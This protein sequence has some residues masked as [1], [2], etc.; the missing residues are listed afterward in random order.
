MRG[1]LVYLDNLKVVLTVV[2]IF[3]HVG[4]AYAATGGFW[5]YMVPPEQGIGWVGRTFGINSGYLMALF[6]LMSGY[7]LPSSWERRAGKGFVTDKLTHLGLPLL[8]GVFVLV[9]L[10]FYLY[11]E[12]YSGNPPLGWWGYYARIYLGIGVPPDGFNAIP[13]GVPQM[14]FGWLWYVEHLL[15]YSLLYAVIR[16]LSGGGRTPFPR[17]RA[18]FPL[19]VGQGVVIAVVT[20]IVRR[21]YPIDHWIP[22]LG[23]IQVEPA[24]L[25]LYLVSFLTGVAARRQ[26]WI[27]TMPK[28]AGY[29]ALVL[30]LLMA[31]PRMFQPWLPRSVGVAIHTSWDMYES[32][33]AVF[34][35]W[36]LLVLFRECF[37]SERPVL[38]WAGRLT[39][40]AYILHVPIVVAWQYGI[41]ENLAAVPQVRFFLVL[42]LAIGTTFAAAFLLK[43]VPVVRKFL[44]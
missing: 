5:P 11:Y 28:T 18:G 31:A 6:F 26:D 39:F 32:F 15:L 8:L 17:V 35:C 25:P 37:D 42:V 9:P 20:V 4:Q 43:K 2:V 1:K 29:L 21:Y 33:M 24:H 38:R 19:I 23:F 27:A 14:N 36:G 12:N 10:V 3:H 16:R 41:G 34:F 22:L 40:A 30:A 13:V 7:F 44:G